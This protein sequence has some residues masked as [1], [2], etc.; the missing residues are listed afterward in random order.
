MDARE[1]ALSMGS[2]YVNQLA[3][4]CELYATL[5]DAGML[6]LASREGDGTANDAA[7]SAWDML[8][9]KYNAL[10][11]AAQL[12]DGGAGVD[13]FELAESVSRLLDDECG[14]DELDIA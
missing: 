5:M 12:R 9:A 4:R 8:R 2:E 10:E 13:A 11:C 14:L 3:D 6:I 1:F 7:T